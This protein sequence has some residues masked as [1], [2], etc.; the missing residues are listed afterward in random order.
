MFGNVHPEIWYTAGYALFLVAAAMGLESLGRHAHKRSQQFHSAGFKYLEHLDVWECPAGQSLQRIAFD[1][2]KR[3]ARYRAPAKACNSCSLKNNCTDSDEG[4]ELEHHLDSWLQSEM[5]KFH[6]GISL[7]LYF[8]AGLILVVELLR[9]NH[10][11]EFAV[12]LGAA[13]PVVIFGARTW[14]ASR[15]KRIEG[16]DAILQ[17]RMEWK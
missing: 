4:R 5:S 3:V 2:E 11:S 6:R 15:E 8:L 1:E 9:E 10:P 17:Q 12:L 16:S 7:A 14:S 13:A